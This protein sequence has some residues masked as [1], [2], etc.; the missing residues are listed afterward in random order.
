MIILNT[1]LM[2][3]VFKDIKTHRYE[4]NWKETLPKKL[5]VFSI[6]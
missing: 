1:Q 4:N 3:V 6:L 2:C 5:L